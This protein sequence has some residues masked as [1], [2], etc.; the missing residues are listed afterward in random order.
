MAEYGLYGAMVR[1]SLPLPETIVKS[2]K[3][4][5]LESTAPW[6]LSMYR[7]SFDVSPQ[8]KSKDAEGDNPGGSQAEVLNREE[9]RSESIAALRA[10]AQAHAA[11]LMTGSDRADF[12]PTPSDASGDRDESSSTE[13]D[14]GDVSVTQSD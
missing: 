3:E 2:A 7:K 5:V 1:H 4:G 11:R 12:S 14:C 9:F 8:Q 6:L 10:R 13:L